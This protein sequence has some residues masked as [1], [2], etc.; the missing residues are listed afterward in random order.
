M[1]RWTLPLLFAFSL[2]VVVAAP[3]VGAM[4]VPFSAVFGDPASGPARLLWELRIPRVLL[5]WI[6][7]STLAICGLVFQALFRNPL[8]SPDMLGVSTGAAFG[9]VL[10]IRL[11]LAFSLFG[12]SGLS[13]A[14]FAGALLATFAIYLA[15]TVKRG[16]MSEGTLLLAGIAMSFLFGSAN[17][18]VQYSGGY[19]DTFRMMRWSMGGIQT[20]G[21]SSVWAT[22]PALAA[23]LVTALVSSRELDLF[24][25]GEEIAAGRGVAVSR[26]RKLLFTIVSVVVGV[27]V[28][29]CGPIAFVGLMAPHICRKFVG[30]DH[31]RLTLASFF[32]GGAF[33]VLCDT[34]A[35]IL[36]APAEV[37]VG[38]LTS[39]AGSIFFLW[40]LLRER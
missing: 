1:K 10:Y 11:G 22:L 30:E 13:F 25:C 18:I 17:M 14:A 32:F 24:V 5:G 36:W 39:C 37:P 8:A 33:L 12:I 15:S 20:V 35:R 40:L 3:F 34:A 2:T 26:L 38:I 27:N 4:N 6:T 7:G 9:A 28:A 19:T 23:I 16:G 21:F 29:A 31:R